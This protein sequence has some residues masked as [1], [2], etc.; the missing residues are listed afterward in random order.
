MEII[1][2]NIMRL[3]LFIII[4]RLILM[5]MTFALVGIGWIATR[6]KNKNQ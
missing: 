5:V 1:L 4:I 2:V 3:I 6:T